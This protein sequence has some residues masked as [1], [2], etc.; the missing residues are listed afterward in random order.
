M[1]DTIGIFGGAFDPLHKGHI[2]SIQDINEIVNFSELK[3]VP[4]NIP[5]LKKVT[6]A[7]KEERFQMLKLVFDDVENIKIDPC[8]LEKEGISYTVK[9]LED[10]SNKSKPNQHFSLIMGLDAFMNLTSW[11]NYERILELSSI[12]VLKRP[13]YVL[14]QKYLKQFQE[15]IT[16]ELEEFLNSTGKIIFFTLTQLDISSTQIKKAIRDGKPFEEN[17]DQRI[18]NFIK[19]KSIY[20]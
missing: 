9:T 6:V 16:D 2:K 17:L 18:V 20:K 1:S 15:A 11:K 14:D 8:E 5:A 19:D 12:L 4:C 3:I 7:S 10:L 13:S